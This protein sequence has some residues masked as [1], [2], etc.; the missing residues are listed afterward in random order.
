[1]VAKFYIPTNSE[2]A[3]SKRVFPHPSQHSL[4]CGLFLLVDI[5][6]DFPG[7]SDGGESACNAG[8]P[9][10][11]PESGRS[12]GEGIG[13][14]LQDF[15]LEN[16]WTEEPVKLQSKEV[17]RVRHTYSWIHIYMYK[18]IKLKI[19]LLW[20]NIHKIKFDILSIQFCGTK[21]INI[22]MLNIIVIIS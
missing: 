20:E 11:V 7:G 3:T 15:C 21:F 4:S 12:S 19:T 13:N 22:L 6:G 1:M 10:S 5:L 9:G 18:Y 16:P 17:Q 14:P 8:N 2:Q